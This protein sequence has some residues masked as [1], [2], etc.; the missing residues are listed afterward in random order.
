M[1]TIIEI[2]LTVAMLGMLFGLICLF[3][4]LWWVKK[5]WQAAALVVGAFVAVGIIGSVPVPRPAGIS[6]ADWNERVSVC[7]AA[8]K[9]R[10]CPLAKAD[11][12][13]ARAEIAKAGASSKTSIGPEMAS[14]APANAEAAFLETNKKL[15]AATAPCDW[16]IRAAAKTHGRI[17][18]YN[19]AVK[20]K[21]TCNQATSDIYEVTF[22]A[23][24]HSQK[25]VF[26]IFLRPP[27]GCKPIAMRRFCDFSH[28]ALRRGAMN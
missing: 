1:E 8:N 28:H 11:V 4:P 7:K 22:D 23:P 19:A 14:L 12:D 24:R 9:S 27:R 6:E 2:A 25:S 16:A 10:Y 20:A 5:R 15:I 21:D 17:V 26:V 3:K 18:G 13:T